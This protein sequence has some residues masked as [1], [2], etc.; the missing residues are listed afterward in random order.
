MGG[1]KIMQPAEIPPLRGTYKP[2]IL[3]TVLEIPKDTRTEQ[4]K[5]C[6]EFLFFVSQMRMWG[7]VNDAIGM[8]G[9]VPKNHD[10][11]CAMCITRHKGTL[12]ELLFGEV[13]ASQ[14]RSASAFVRGLNQKEDD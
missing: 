9:G 1:S 13:T 10:G 14:L 4:E 12:A 5:A 6:D 3:S 8:V 11:D 7:D 2:R